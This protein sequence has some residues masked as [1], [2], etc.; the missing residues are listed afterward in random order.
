LICLFNYPKLIDQIEAKNMLQSFK[1]VD[2][3][4][5][6]WQAIEHDGACIVEGVLTPQQI[7]D[8][9]SDFKPY[10]SDQSWGIDELGYKD[11]FYGLQTKRLHGLF[12]KSTQME[13][14]LLNPVFQNMA[15]YFLCQEKRSRS[16]RLSNA[17]LMVIGKDQSNQMY[18]RDASSWH[19]AQSFEGNN[20]ILV[21]A[22]IALTPF[23]E[24]NGATRVVPGS[25]L[26]PEEREPKAHESC[27][28]VM[29]RGAALLYSGNVLH[30]GGNNQEPE[31]RIGLYM[32]YIVSWLRL[33]ENHLVTNDASDIYKMS[34]AARTLLDV[35][36]GGYTVLA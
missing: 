6:I 29:P 8:L 23:T 3:Q 5:Q 36:E 7:D 32:G 19:R 33:I 34:E 35:S 9:V 25:H 27:L 28:A 18:H 15:K 16:V 10:L 2:D 1:T 17:E 4:I 30:S 20:E 26:W 22:N 13:E 31:Q 11:E 21:S 24:T 14:V 12:S